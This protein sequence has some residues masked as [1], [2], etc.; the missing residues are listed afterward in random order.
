MTTRP[1]LFHLYT[2]TSSLYSNLFALMLIK[3]RAGVVAI[4]SK[5]AAHEDEMHHHGLPIRE[6]FEL[7]VLGC[8]RMCV[9]SPAK[10][11]YKNNIGQHSVPLWH[12]CVIPQTSPT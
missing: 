5:T 9:C 2:T 4:I 3:M 11:N 7:L 1:A 8:A 12:L 10:P 6:L